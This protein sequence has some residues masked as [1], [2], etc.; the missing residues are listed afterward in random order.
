MLE[1]YSKKTCSLTVLHSS[2]VTGRHCCSLMVVHCCSVAR[3]HCTLSTTSHCSS[4]T[5]L[6]CSAGTAS[7]TRVVIRGCRAATTEELTEEASE[8]DDTVDVE[9]IREEEEEE[10]E[11]REAIISEIFGPMLATTSATTFCSLICGAARLEAAAIRT[12]RS[13]EEAMAS[14]R[15]GLRWAPGS[16]VLYRGQSQARGIPRLS[17]GMG[18][19]W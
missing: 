6:H 7:D 13:L 10:E 15:P 16:Q 8:P 11:E 9:P 1:I 14:A 19:E 4:E 17:N 18:T 12:R 5:T 2:L 3:V